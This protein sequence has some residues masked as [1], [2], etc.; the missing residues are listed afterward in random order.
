MLL[1][2]NSLQ[3]SSSKQTHF[4]KPMNRVKNIALDIAATRNLFVQKKWKVFFR[5]VQE[6][7]ECRHTIVCVVPMYHHHSNLCIFVR[8]TLKS[9]C[10]TSTPEKSVVFYFSAEEENE[11]C[12]EWRT[13]CSER[14]LKHFNFRLFNITTHIKWFK[15]IVIWLL[16]FFYL[17]FFH[18]IGQP[19]WSCINN[20]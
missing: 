2:T 7:C 19:Y 12:G 15:C 4:L 10:S 9:K 20:F 14:A 16:V 18:E 11:T 5:I 1:I 6:E 17:G 8:N 13:L 3:I